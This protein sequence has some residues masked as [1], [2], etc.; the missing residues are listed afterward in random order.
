MG[1]R[2][3]AETMA[4][5]LY[6]VRKALDPEFVEQERARQRALGPTRWIG[7][8]DDPDYAA[9]QAEYGATE[10]RRKQVRLRMAA[11]RARRRAE[12]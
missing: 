4:C 3:I 11:L 8:R 1:R 2:A 6:T 7:R 12:S 9:Y 5:S 10:E